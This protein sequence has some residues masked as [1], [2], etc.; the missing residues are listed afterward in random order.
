ML[1]EVSDA[2]WIACEI[3]AS[4]GNV[5]EGYFRELPDAANNP[6]FTL[7]KL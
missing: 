1:G 2:R 5:V 6:V 4:R 7:T 3:G